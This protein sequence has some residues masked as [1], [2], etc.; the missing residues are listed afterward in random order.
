M[1][2]WGLGNFDNDDALDWVCDLEETKGPA[3]LDETLDAVSEDSSTPVCTSALAAAEI[4]AALK[5][6]PAPDLTDEALS[7]VKENA[8]PPAPELLAKAR[9]ACVLIKTDS[10][11]RELWDE[12]EQLADWLAIVADTERRL[13]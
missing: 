13:A 1:G 10:E 6:A 12:V 2:A 7:W 11:L 3:F 8:G 9:Q 4:V 5:G